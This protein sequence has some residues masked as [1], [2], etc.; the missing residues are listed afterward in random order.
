MKNWSCNGKTGANQTNA[1]SGVPDTEF[2]FLGGERSEICSVKIS[3][4]DFY[5]HES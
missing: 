4:D 2:Q 3:P 5:P 1:N